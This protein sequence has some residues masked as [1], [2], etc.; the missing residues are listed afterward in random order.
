MLSFRRNLVSFI[1]KLAIFLLIQAKHKKKIK[2]KKFTNVKIY[3][4]YSANLG[5]FSFLLTVF[6]LLNPVVIFSQTSSPDSTI[7][8]LMNQVSKENLKIYVDTLS[9][10]N[11]HKSRITYTD[12]NRWSTSYIK[13][14]FDSFSGL[15]SV[16]LDTFLITSATPPYNSEFL[17]NIVA[18]IEGVEEP[19]K[20]LAI[21]GHLDCSA[22]RGPNYNSDWQ[23]V[24]AQ[25]ADDNASG[26]AAIFEIARILSDPGNGWS[27]KYTLQFVA[28]AA[29]EYHPVYSGHHIGSFTFAKRAYAKN[30]EIVGVYNVD[31]IGYNNTGNYHVDIVSDNRSQFLG[32]KFLEIISDYQINLHTNQPPFPYA[33]YSDHESFWIFQ[34]PTILLI[35]NAPPWDDNLPWYEKNPYYHTEEDKPSTVNLDQV[36]KITKTVIGAV[37]SF[38]KVTSGIA[39]GGEQNLRIPEEFI[40]F[41]NYP[42][43]FNAETNIKY[44][45]KSRNHVKIKIFSIF[46][47]LLTTLTDQ[48]QPAG[49]RS[50]VWNGR[51]NNNK[52]LASGIYL[53]TIE[54]N[55]RRSTR[56]LI[57]NK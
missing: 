29:E 13:Q 4:I 41:Q 24:K 48:I 10:A 23:T 44:F 47:Q 21:T 57:L 38:S 14:T 27:S 6:L 1:G 33:T 56:K 37:G 42:N 49:D 52:I 5:M 12:G 28:F 19:D 55:N 36:E 7:L 39:E 9:Y 20:I 17:Y 16:K 26:L 34:Y 50:I 15:S 40:L 53:C 51:D 45:L 30:S 32:V 35:E 46:G 2:E 54:I 8:L 25:A 11:G 43:P 18:T 3:K 22:S 31:M